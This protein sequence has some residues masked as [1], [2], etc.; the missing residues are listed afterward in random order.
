MLRATCLQIT[1]QARSQL[2][3][4]FDCNRHGRQDQISVNDSLDRFGSG[5]VGYNRQPYLQPIARVHAE[6]GISIYRQRVDR[7]QCRRS[8]WHGNGYFGRS[9]PL[10]NRAHVDCHILC[11]KPKAC[12]LKQAAHSQRIGLWRRRLCGHELHCPIYDGCASSKSQN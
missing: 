10:R 12:G 3:F 4:S 9:H 6:D 1:R 11:G 8:G 5:N 7:T 2:V